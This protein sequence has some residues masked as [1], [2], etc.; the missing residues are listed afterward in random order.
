MSTRQSRFSVVCVL[1]SLE[2]CI[3]QFSSSGQNLILNGDFEN[4]GATASLYNLSNDL[5]NSLV[6]N[7]TA[8]GNGQEI[9]LMTTDTTYGLPPESGLWKVAIHKAGYPN[10][11]TDDAF[12]FTL[13]APVLPG[14]QYALS[15]YGQLVPT[16]DNPGNGPVQIGLSSSPTNFGTL[17]FTGTP[18]TDAW[19]HLVG[20]FTAPL[21]AGYLTV[22]ID[23]GAI[24][25]WAHID[26]FSLT[27][28]PEPGTLTLLSSL[29]L[30]TF[31]ARYARK[32]S[33]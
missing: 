13:S 10:S 11:G 28:V 4:N 9:D 32:R 23:P 5:F 18:A 30:A 14:Q 33:T 26:N 8:F 12:S 2:A 1:I 24:P 29:A 15:F 27:L 3:G 20:T 31:F 25:T 6:Y 16:V 22:Q 21:N 17:V 7:A 19:T